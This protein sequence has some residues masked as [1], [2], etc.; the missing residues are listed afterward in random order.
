MSRYGDTGPYRSDNVRCVPCQVN[1]SEKRPG[2]ACAQGVKHPKAKL[3]N[4]KV[5]RIFHSEDAMEDLAERYGVNY[6]TILRIKHKKI[7]RHV[8]GKEHV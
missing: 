1:N 6:S 2:G 8:L 3:T 7:W 5:I 4:K